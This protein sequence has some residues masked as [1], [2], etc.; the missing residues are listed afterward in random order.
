M[1]K[2]N[3]DKHENEHKGEH[4][5]DTGHEWDGIR[6]LKNL[7]PRWWMIGFHASWIFCIVYFILYPSIPLANRSTKGILG[8]T[9]IKEYKEAVEENDKIKAPFLSKISTMSPQAILADAGIRNFTEQSTKT[10]FGDSCSACHGAGGQGKKGMYPNLTDDDWLY[11]G[12]INSIL[13][14]ITDGRQGFMPAQKDILDEPTINK[15]ADF[16]MS[17]PQGN[18]TR[19]GWNSFTN[20][21]CIACHGNNAKGGALNGNKS[22]AANLTD[23]IWRF[24]GTRE[25]VLQT[26]RFGVN[27]DYAESRK[28]VMPAWGERLTP[29]QIKML[30]VKVYSL[31]GGQK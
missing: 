12:D 17:L 21:G 11:G 9:M 24:G 27:Q 6:E 14:T 5:P 16:V 4:G 28:A 31:S 23:K 10:L 15:L 26:I 7:P 18:A 25:A 30:A 13:E 8:W 19:D 20:S 1:E 22:G 29:D 3:N 2:N